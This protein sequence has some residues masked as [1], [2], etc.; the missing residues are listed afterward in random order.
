M[1]ANRDIRTPGDLLW[2]LI[3]E[4]RLQIAFELNDIARRINQH[5][6]PMFVIR[7]FKTRPGRYQQFDPQFFDM[8]DHAREVFH[9]Q[10]SE[11]E[12][13]RIGPRGKFDRTAL[14]MAYQ[15]QGATET[16][17][18]AVVKYA[19]GL[20]TEDIRIPFGRLLQIAAGYGDVGNVAPGRDLRIVQ[21][22][23]ARRYF[24]HIFNELRNK[25]C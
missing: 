14:Q 19:Y 21:Q 25:N 6:C 3:A 9:L 20:R 2:P 8:G 23:W 5:E 12:M 4:F 7:I 22:S 11:P 15:L 24:F 18:D 17:R 10:E 1:H 16:K 13:S